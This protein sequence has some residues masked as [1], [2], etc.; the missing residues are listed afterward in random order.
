V[1][2]TTYSYHRHLPE[3]GEQPTW[4]V[5]LRYPCTDLDRLLRR[6]EV[7]APKI[8]RQSADEGGKVI[9]PTDRLPLP[10]RRHPWYSFLLEA[11]PSSGP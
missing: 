8:S 4:H 9:S 6:Q 3:R 1:V 10:P 7:E 11:E 2:I 5:K